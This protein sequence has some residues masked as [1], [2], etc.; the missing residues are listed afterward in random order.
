MLRGDPQ[1]DR[2]VPRTGF[3]ARLTL[4]SALAMAVLA[5]FA[6][7]LSLAV[8]RLADRWGAELAQSATLRISAPPDQMQ[9]QTRAAMRVLETTR[10][11]AA[12]RVLSADDQHA[13]LAPWFG[14][15]LDLSG[16]PVPQLIEITEE[17]GGLDA[18]GLRLRLAAEAP[19][20]VF[21]D[22]TRWRAPLTRAAW[23]LRL[24]GWVS[25]FLI[26]GTTAAIITLAAGAALSANAQVIAVLRLVGATD[27]YITSAFVRRF[28]VRAVIGAAFG[29]GLAM[30][31]MRALPAVGEAAPILTGL[32]FRGWHWFVP[33]FVPV[34]AGGVAFLATRAAA[35]RSLERLS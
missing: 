18:A 26:I 14:E 27:A 1:A 11:V 32:G 15:G 33:L 2:I 13:L 31:A 4:F 10:G 8:G 29:T 22:H 23:R 19:G 3:T 7:A 12:A 17:S 9:A 24:L 25:I 20:A 28:T 34:L 6:L 21:D 5:V 35:A 16:L 30:L